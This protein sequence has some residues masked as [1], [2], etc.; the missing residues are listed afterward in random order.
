MVP[1]AVKNVMTSTFVCLTSLILTPDPWYRTA[2]NRMKLDVAVAAVANA[3]IPLTES[4]T[5]TQITIVSLII[6]CA[7]SKCLYD[8][9]D[10]YVGHI[11]TECQ[12]QNIRHVSSSL[13]Y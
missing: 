12:A 13:L 2:P 8:K 5:H 7:V 3:A 4:K 11:H 9:A 1:Y 10:A 6:L